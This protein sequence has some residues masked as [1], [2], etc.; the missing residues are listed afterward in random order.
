[1]RSETFMDLIG[2]I[3]NRFIIEA[4]TRSAE[5]NSL[6]HSWIKRIPA[7]A[8]VAACL[9]IGMLVLLN[10]AQ[11]T[12]PSGYSNLPKL[13]VNTEFGTFGFEGY[14]AYDVGELNNGNPWTENN[15]LTIMPV[16]T[17]PGKYDGAG[18]PLNGLS[19]E[20]MMA[21]AEKLA[22]LFGLQIISLETEPTQAQIEQILQKLKDADASEEEIRQNTSTYKATAECKGARIEV[23]KDGHIVLT[24]TPETADLAKEIGKLS[25]YDS[26][27]ID[28]DF[29]YETIDGI[30]YSF[31]LPL[32]EGYSFSYSNTSH[33]QAKTITQYLFSEYGSFMRIQKPGYGLTAAYTYNGVLMCQNTFVYDD[34][35]SLTDRIL[36]YNFRRL[37]FSPTDSGG[38][39]AI[40]YDN[41]DLSQKIGDYPIITAKDARKL[42]LKKHYVTSVPEDFPGEKYIAHVE[43]IYRTSRFDTVYMPYYRFLVELPTM[44][45][46][47]GLKTFGAFYVPAVK[48][49]FLESMPIWNGSF[50]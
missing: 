50:N 25:A 34:G 42:L 17:N 45:R 28:F 35:G 16:F 44:A 1:M 10:P 43:L 46:D 47:N 27:T 38:L 37:S 36:N 33:E 29:G 40:R 39:S 21:E 2:Q 23:N 20:E 11:P 49:E 4:D 30:R 7:I 5:A 3:D 24:L 31:G 19:P 8:A 41:A 22:D 9:I 18:I 26:F 13:A 15:S 14:L 48:G 12:D 6:R 32:P